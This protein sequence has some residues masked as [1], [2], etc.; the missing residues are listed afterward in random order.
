M[1]GILEKFNLK[2]SSSNILI[3]TIFLISSEFKLQF[4][5]ELKVK[6]DVSKKLLKLQNGK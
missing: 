3:G 4:I 1:Y 5:S 6:I 2:F